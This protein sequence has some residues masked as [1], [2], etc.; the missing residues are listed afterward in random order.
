MRIFIRKVVLFLVMFLAC[1][2]LYLF[3]IQKTD[4][5]FKKRIESLSF[6]MPQN[7]VLVIGNSFA[8]DGINT[9]YLSNN[10]FPSY[11]L[12]LGGSSVSTSYIQ[13]HEYLTRYNYKPK[14]VVL[15]IG[16]YYQ[17]FDDEVINPIVDFTQDNRRWR[18]KD[19]P[20]LKFRWLF[21]ELLKKMVS[22]V[23][24]EA[25]LT[26]GQLRFSKQVADNTVVDS[27]RN[28]P[29]D[30]YKGSSQIQR[31]IDLCSDYN[32]KLIILEMPGYK[33]TRHKKSFNCIV[34]DE[35][36]NNGILFDYNNFEDCS[37]YDDKKDWI[38]KSHL[39]IFGAQKLTEKLLSDL[40]R[41]NTG[42]DG[43]F[44]CN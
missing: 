44:E 19:L 7:E 42:S 36:K 2:F 33:K 16:S 8:M 35:D 24:R 40:N 4:W 3:I 15:G 14:Y 29:L 18:I 43:I 32:I 9:E 17:S 13:L 28:F 25:Y 27:D 23:H 12:S 21:K 31:I 38:A 34:L 22:K 30:R 10:G 39:N 5:N 1:N 37:I 26:Y 41:S 11:N 6:N 20:M